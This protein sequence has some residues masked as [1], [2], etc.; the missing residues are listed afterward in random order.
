MCP[1]AAGTSFEP[2]RHCFTY[3]RVTWP[4]YLGERHRGRL[5]ERLVRIETILVA[6]SGTT[7]REKAN[8]AVVEFPK[9]PRCSKQFPVRNNLLHPL[10]GPPPQT[11]RR[12]SGPMPRPRQLARVRGWSAG[13]RAGAGERAGY[14]GATWRSY[15]GYEPVKPLRRGTASDAYKAD[16]LRVRQNHRVLLHDIRPSCPL[17]PYEH[18]FVGHYTS[19]FGPGRRHVRVERLR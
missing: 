3:Q 12:V 1:N 7:A 10:T 11:A 6:I 13:S 15:Q 9:P 18:L 5:L 16:V 14:A 19:G 17:C 2:H 4:P 8:P